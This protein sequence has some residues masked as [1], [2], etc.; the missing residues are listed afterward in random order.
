MKPGD[1]DA[2]AGE[3]AKPRSSPQRT[4]GCVC[5]FLGWSQGSGRTNERLIAPRLSTLRCH[6]PLPRLRPCGTAQRSRRAAREQGRDLVRHETAHECC[7]VPEGKQ[8]RRATP[9]PVGSAAAPGQRSS[10]KLWTFPAATRKLLET[11]PTRR[12]PPV[13]NDPSSVAF[14][15]APQ[16]ERRADRR[17]TPQRA[18]AHE[19]PNVDC[20]DL[21]GT[22]TE[23]TP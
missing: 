20:S 16:H 13:P 9:A 6:T 17:T 2:L 15:F 22:R 7:G 19:K 5:R 8:R 10:T 3:A 4:S 1:P 14:G 12:S 23:P 18:P 11:P 21:L